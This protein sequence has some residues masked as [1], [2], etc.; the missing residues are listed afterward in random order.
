MTAPAIPQ[1]SLQTIL[2]PKWKSALNRLRQ[3]RSGGNG[4]FYLLALVALGFWAAVFG[5]SY[6]ILRYIQST[7]EVGVPLAAKFLG[8]ILLAFA[9]LL[10][11][12]N[13]ITA[14]SSFFLAKDLDLLVSS[15]IDW[16]RLYFAKLGETLLHS[17]WMVA[18]MA[19]PIFT[20]YGMV[21]GGGPLFPLV[22]LA[23]L[24]PYFVMPCVLGSA[25]TL[26]LV[27]VFPARRTRDLLS[28]I[29]IGAFG[30]LVLLFRLI[31]PEQLARPEGVRNLLDYLSALRT[32]T[33]PFLPSEWATGMVMNWL[34]HVADPLPIVLL[35]TTAAGLRGPRCH[36]P[37]AALSHRVLQGPGGRRTLRAGTGLVGDPGPAV[38]PHA[39]VQAGVRP[40][41]PA[42]L[43]PRHDPVEPAHPAGR[44]AGGLRLQ[45]Q[46]AAAVQG[47]GGPGLPRDPGR[48]SQSRPGGLRAR[49]GRGP[50]RLPRGLAGGEADVA[51]PL[52]PARPA[53]RSCGASTGRGRSRCWCWRS[54]STSAPTSCCRPPRS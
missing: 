17:S 24:L 38:P 25:L 16:L 34:Q 9:S 18:L 33:S 45:H 5:L 8:I 31:R 35:W 3:E 46:D 54:A 6:K 30:G 53:S 47:R 4:K 48:L 1:P 42:G 26:I 21:F 32:P 37:W 52:E 20:A 2:I 29:A 28:L 12:S 39:G 36:A 19:V 15:P 51:A 7:T 27:N 44:A 50:L 40:E 22:V 10:L 49:R 41:G 23:A 43:L 14:L 13:L 11:L